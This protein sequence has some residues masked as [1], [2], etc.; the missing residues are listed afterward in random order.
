MYWQKLTA[1]Q[2]RLTLGVAAS[3][4]II[5]G[6]AGYLSPADESAAA[7]EAAATPGRDAGQGTA[8]PTSRLRFTRWKHASGLFSADVPEGW[9]ID[10][11]IGDA[12]DQGPF[13]LN[14]T[15]A[16]VR[17]VISLGHNWVS[18]MEF[19][20]GPYQPGAATIERLLLPDFIRRQGY[21]ASRIVYRTRNRRVSM[22][23]EIGVPIPFDSGTLGFLLTAPDGSY[24]AGTAMGETM[25]IASPGTPGLWRLRLFATAIAPATAPAQADVR[26]ALDR[27]TSTLDLSPQFFA[28]WNQAFTH[29]QQQ[30]RD[31]SRQMDQVFSRYLQSASRSTAGSRRDSA[32][33][34]AGMM[35]GG[36][37]GENT[38]TGERYWVTNDSA[39]WWVSDNGTVVG[40]NTGA[41]PAVNAN[42]KPL[43][44]R[45]Q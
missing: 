25:Y 19:Q 29:T 31:Y 7:L 24:S 13:R 18:Y 17:S 16:D 20:Y 9:T 4:V 33:D 11:A 35:R 43:V 12:M 36:Q 23:S 30:M 26:A 28:L 34:W 41:P 6:V 32:E 3:G 2:R 21:T 14:A 22:P 38:E 44:M 42:W 39:N 10:G 8:P 27:A 1:S 37:Y 5:I 45:G 40:N 15:S